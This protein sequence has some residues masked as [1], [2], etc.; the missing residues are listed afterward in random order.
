VLAGANGANANIRVGVNA[1]SGDL[2]HPLTTRARDMAT[3]AGRIII[4]TGNFSEPAWDESFNVIV[5]V[6]AGAPQ[7]QQLSA[8]ID[9]LIAPPQAAHGAVIVWS[10]PG[11]VPAA[12]F[13]ERTRRLLVV[14]ELRSDIRGVGMRIAAIQDGAA[15]AGL[16]EL[17]A[18]L[19][20]LVPAAPPLVGA[21]V[22]APVPGGRGLGR[23]ADDG[24]RGRG[25]AGGRGGMPGR[26][27]RGGGRWV[28]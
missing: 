16:P 28:N 1:R 18:A 6:R 22:V 27:G 11:P 15:P 7:Y 9:Q 25:R 12:A 10:A 8:Y 20:D 23:G 2:M 5:E 14:N 24:G 21:P 26:Q 17:I 3:G 19:Q 13:L 4:S